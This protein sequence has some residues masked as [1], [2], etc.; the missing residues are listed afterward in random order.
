M[1]ELRRIYENLTNEKLLNRRALGLDGLSV[2]AHKVVEEILIERSVEFPPIPNQTINLK[3]LK[4]N[5][6][7]SKFDISM[8]ILFYLFI[9]LIA[10]GLWDGK[11][12]TQ[13]RFSFLIQGNNA[14]YV[15]ILVTLIFSYWILRKILLSKKELLKRR[16]QE[17]QITDLMYWAAIG[18]VERV[19]EL[20]DWKVNINEVDVDGSTALTYAQ[21]NKRTE[22]IDLIK[23]AR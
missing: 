2:E 7:M 9:S 3:K 18:D 20:L 19:K 17:G 8:A 5:K 12:Q 23:N 16:W 11:Q 1:S 6:G 4:N 10:F 15:W 22:I 21:S 14:I 13:G